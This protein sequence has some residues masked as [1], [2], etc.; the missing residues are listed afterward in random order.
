MEQGT[1]QVLVIVIAVAALGGVAAYFVARY[2]KG[3][4]NISLA[5]TDFDYGA[6]VR[7]SFDL[8][9]RKE[10]K[11]NSLTASIVAKETRRER[12]LDG[13]SHTHTSEVYRYG[14]TLESAKVYPAGTTTRYEFLLHVPAERP[15]GL[16]GSALGQ[17]LNAGLNLLGG[18]RL[19]WS[20]EVR[21]DAEGVDLAASRTIRVAG[22][23]GFL[24]F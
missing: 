6:E 17:V 2:L 7:G 24:G 1:I 8:L 16:G 9:A 18:R 20:V 19:N 14:Q 15:S 22:S 23:G 4:I 5:G 10:I 21:L 11:G 3:S 12:G 13:K